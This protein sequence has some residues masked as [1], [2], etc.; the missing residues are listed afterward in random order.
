MVWQSGDIQSFSHFWFGSCVHIPKQHRRKLDA[1]AKKCIFVGYDDDTKGFRVLD[2]N[3]IVSVVRDVKFLMEEPTTVTIF[4]EV[5]QNRDYPER[6]SSES[7]EG[8]SEVIESDRVGD[9]NFMTPKPG[10]VRKRRS[11]IMDGIESNNVLGSRLRAGSNLT[12]HGLF[13]MLASAIGD[14]DEPKSYEQAM[15]SNNS[16]QWPLAMDEEFKSLVKNKTWSLVDKPTDQKVVDSKWVY[17]IKRNSDEAI[18]RFRAR[19]VAGGFTQQYGI[20]YEETFSPVVRFSSVRAILA[21]AAERNL[22]IKQFDVKTAFLNSE[23][24]NIN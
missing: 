5:E 19:L 4:D 3:K 24:I 11:S 18:D 17:K 22:F 16:E 6:E 12:D 13:A 21:I 9:L 23:A 20:D 8:E 15:N 2:E 10:K 1:K 14:D 7:N